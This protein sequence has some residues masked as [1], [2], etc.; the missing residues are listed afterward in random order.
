MSCAFIDGDIFV[1]R[2]G[3]AAQKTHYVYKV[4]GEELHYDSKAEGLKEASKRGNRGKLYR[5]VVPEPVENALY[6]LKSMLENSMYR[7]KVEEYKIYLTSLDRSNFRFKRAT[8]K[9]Y[10]GNRK[11]P[12]PVHFQAIRDYLIDVYGAEIVSGIEADDQMAIDA[13]AHK[14]GIIC[15]IDKDLDMIPGAHYNFVTE[16]F[17]HTEDPGHLK[18]HE[19]R[20]KLIGGGLVWFYA[21]ML[22]GDNA[23]NIP[24]LKGFGPVSVANL[25]G[26]LRTEEDMVR[27]VF[28]AYA[29]VHKHHSKEEVEEIFLEVADLLWIQRSQNEIKSEHLRSLL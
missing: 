13:L 12:R 8:I 20:R 29:E 17:Y 11:Q 10:K 22:L 26:G 4:D 25:L 16:T 7:M 9:P 1:Y 3:F 23:D 28:E 5:R 21:Q 19:G 27:C 24:G 14:D 18:L 15:T 6:L 2:A